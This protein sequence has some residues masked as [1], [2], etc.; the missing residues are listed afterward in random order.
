MRRTGLQIL[1]RLFGLLIPLEILGICLWWVSTLDPASG[2]WAL[3]QIV[4]T[5]TLTFSFMAIMRKRG[6]YQ[7]DER[8][9]SY[10]ERS[11]MIAALIGLVTL[12]Q[13]TVVE[14]ITG[15]N[16]KAVEIFFVVAFVFM[17][18]LAVHTIIPHI[19]YRSR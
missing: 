4:L 1:L 8:T 17:V 2:F 14:I 7:T 12:I 6:F 13:I 16:F 10:N 5:L 11:V 19:Q 18:T 15:L 3:L 9:E